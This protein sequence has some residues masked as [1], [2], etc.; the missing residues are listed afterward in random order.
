VAFF[1]TQFLCK[2]C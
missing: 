1:S 2:F